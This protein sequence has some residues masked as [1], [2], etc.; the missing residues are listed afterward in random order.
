MYT[1]V[2]YAR[3]DAGTRGAT[4]S[5]HMGTVGFDWY[6]NELRRVRHH[7]PFS[8]TETAGQGMSHFG[9]D[10]ELGRDF[11]GL[12][13]GKAQPRTPIETGIQSV[14]TCLAARESALRGR[15]VKVRQV[16]QVG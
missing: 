11:M 14:Y 3:R 16:G 8:A 9:G 10:I 12:I 5:G 2:F 13:Q 7:A 6:S 15:F 4:V 1:Q